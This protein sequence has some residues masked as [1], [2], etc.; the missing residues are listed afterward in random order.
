M[1]TKTLF[2]AALLVGAFVWYSNRSGWRPDGARTDGPM[3]T[4]GVALSAG[5][6]PDEINNI[7]IY[8]ASKNSV[9]YITSTVYEQDFFF[10]MRESQ[11]IGS[12]FI[13]NA[14]GQILTNNHVISGSSD[15]EVTLSDKDKTRYKAR[16]VWKDRVNDLGLIKIDTK[17]KSLPVLKLGN[18]D[19]LQEG[20][21][22][23]AIGNPFG[24]SSTLTTGIVSAL[25]RT[26]RGDNQELEGMI[27]T[28]AAINSGNSGGPL[29]DSQ[30]NVI[31]INTAIYGQ[32]GSIG[33]GFAMPIN[34]ATR[35]LEDFKSGIRPAQPSIGI[36]TV[37]IEGDWARALSL[38]EDLGLLIDA[39]QAGTPAAQAGLKGADRRV[40]IGNYIVNVGGD[41]I[42]HVDGKKVQNADDVIKAASRKHAGDK[43][44]LT[45][46]RGGQSRKVSVTL[47]AL[48]DNA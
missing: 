38:P 11:G 45:V 12:G 37:A 27:Q 40:R 4:P 18:S 22:V 42:T 29:L 28:D 19:G 17:G 36:R 26:I 25:G 24:L 2:L 32:G 48:D 31:G 8:K 34:R 1:K 46:F 44:E 5:L 10:G 21:K 7:D 13:I 14:D 23:L 43:L 6:S 47:A 39:V 9:V 15:I 35:M 20:Q 30:G 16:V 33:I 41:L 3:F